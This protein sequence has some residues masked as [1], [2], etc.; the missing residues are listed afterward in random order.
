MEFQALDRLSDYPLIGGFDR[1]WHVG[2]SF[3]LFLLNLGDAGATVNWSIDEKACTA[4]TYTFTHAGSCKISATIL[5]PDGSRETLT[6][7]MEVK[8]GS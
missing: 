6:K 7:I 8:D 2:D 5:Y 3:R 4:D 1:A